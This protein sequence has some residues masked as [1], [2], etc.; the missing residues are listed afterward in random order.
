LLN[1]VKEGITLWHTSVGMGGASE[2]ESRRGWE[3][4]TGRERKV[5]SGV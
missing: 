4:G 3:E 2:R 5:G 1:V